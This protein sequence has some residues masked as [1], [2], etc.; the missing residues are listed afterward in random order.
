MTTVIWRLAGPHYH[1]AL[2][3]LL[4]PHREP[5]DI[6]IAEVEDLFGGPPEAE[7]WRST[8]IGSA[9]LSPLSCAVRGGHS[10]ELG[11]IWLFERVR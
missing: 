8:V 3:V 11:Q 1:D 5:G 10:S 2:L 4:P 9:D 7:C 6:T